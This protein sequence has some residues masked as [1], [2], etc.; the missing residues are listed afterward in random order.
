MMNEKLTALILC[1]AMLISVC[2]LSA[3]TVFSPPDDGGDGEEEPPKTEEPPYEAPPS[4]YDPDDWFT[5]DPAMTFE[6]KLDQTLAFALAKIDYAIKSYDGK[7]PNAYS[8]DLVYKKPGGNTGG[9]V[10]GFWPG[11]LWHAYELSGKEKYKELATTHVASFYKRIDENL[12]VDHHDMGFL[13][14]PSCVAAYKLTD[15]ETARTAAI[16]AADQLLTRYHA[17]AGFIQ[18]WGTVGDPDE[19]RLIIDCIMNLPLLYWASE[20]TGD[21]K[22][23]DVANAH[24]SSTLTT[25][26]REDG[27]TY[28]T[29]YFD[30]ETKLPSHGVTKQ[31]Y[32]DESAWSRGQAWAVYGTALA[33]GYSANP[34]A[35]AKFKEATDYFLAHLP[36][37]NVPY[38]DFDRSGIA[39][40]PRDTSAAAITICGI[41]EGCQYLELTDPD[42][43]RYLAAAEDMMEALIDNFFTA[44]RPI[45]SSNT[46]AN[47]LLAGVTQSKMSGAGIEEMT[48]YGDYYF[49]EALN[50][51]ISLKG[52]EL[53]DPYW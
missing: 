50:R 43:A 49:M 22:Y 17:D 38:W 35:L 8:V 34:E 15:N 11:V 23:A 12:G 47:G 41:L 2:L 28:H 36:E 39:G 40:E 25:I 9:W 18:A 4:D 13:Y 3:C 14:T 37:D 51:F 5:G 42:R 21:T 53:W 30:P 1:V 19:Y 31:G 44:S 46:M 7:F 29:Y 32:S 24:L 16:M 33:Y 10:Q 45:F 52:G 20:E 6:A 27:S 48:P 26:F